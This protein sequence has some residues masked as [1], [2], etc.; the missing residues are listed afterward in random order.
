MTYS[1]IIR[2]S[3]NIKDENI[4]FYIN[5]YTCPEELIKGIHYIIY[6]GLLSY[7]PKT[8]HQCGTMNHEQSIIKHGTKLS[9]VKLGN[10]LFKPALLRLKKQRYLC[11][12][13]DRTFIAETSIVNKHCFISNPIKQT[14]AFELAET[15]SMTLLTLLRI[16]NKKPLLPTSSAILMS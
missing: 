14:I 12:V 2:K 7:K 5:M 16:D 11:K 1:H 13:C 9:T 15:Q 8:C 10:I 6:K 3:L 4:H